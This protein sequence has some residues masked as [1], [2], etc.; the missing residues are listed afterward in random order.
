MICDECLKELNPK[1]RPYKCFHRGR[2]NA[3]EEIIR[4]REENRE[5]KILLS[6]ALL[7]AKKA[8]KESK[9]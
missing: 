7:K 3:E 4:L 9:E 6:E 8:D 2:K 5:L 1:D